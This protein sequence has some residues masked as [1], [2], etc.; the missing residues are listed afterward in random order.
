MR[1]RHTY[2]WLKV[3]ADGLHASPTCASCNRQAT[4][5]QRQGQIRQRINDIHSNMQNCVALLLVLLPIFVVSSLDLPPRLSRTLNERT[6][7]EKRAAGDATAIKGMRRTP[8]APPSA[9]SYDCSQHD[10]VNSIAAKDIARIWGTTKIDKKVC[11][12]GLAWGKHA[13]LHHVC[14]HQGMCILVAHTAAEAVSF[15]LL[16]SSMPWESNRPYCPYRP[17]IHILTPLVCQNLL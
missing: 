6:K 4:T 7:A 16:E 13:C 5:I 11:S 15:V 9:N 12:H 2:R 1:Q 8:S 17:T 10:V 14:M 3:T